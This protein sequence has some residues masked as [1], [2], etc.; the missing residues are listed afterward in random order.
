MKLLL[1][2]DDGIYAKGLHAVYEAF[3]VKYDVTVIAPDREKSAV[4]HG[5]TLNKPLRATPTSLNGNIFG[6]ALNGTPADCIKLGV[7][8]ILD[9]KPDMVISGINPGANVGVNINYSGT[10]AAAKEATLYGILAMAVSMKGF[11]D[12]QYQEAAEFTLYLADK[13][14]NKGLPKG[15]FL[16]VNFPDIPFRQIQGVRF[17]PQDVS[18]YPESISKRFDPKNIP[19]Y[20]HT[21]DFNDFADNDN[22]DRSALYHNYITITPI[23]CDMTDY[24]TLHEMKL[25]GLDDHEKELYNRSGGG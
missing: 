17:S 9:Q 4:G 12:F 3:S 25:W 16:N 10:V 5:I 14:M 11:D 1:T 6:Y 20:W 13:L 21:C 18:F 22:V 19:Y 8:E 7:L 2:N 23:K 24:Q 15:T